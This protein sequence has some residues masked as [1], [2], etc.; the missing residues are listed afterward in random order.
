MSKVLHKRRRQT[1]SKDHQP[2]GLD[3]TK[4]APDTP[5]PKRAIE[6]DSLGRKQAKKPVSLFCDE[7]LAEKNVHQQNTAAVADVPESAPSR[8]ELDATSSGAAD[9]S[10]S[11]SFSS[12]TEDTE[13]VYDM[14]AFW[15]LQDIYGELLVLPLP[16]G[17]AIP[18]DFPPDYPQFM[19]GQEPETLDEVVSKAMAVNHYYQRQIEALPELSSDDL[20][21][22]TQ[23]TDSLSNNDDDHDDD[24]DEQASIP[25]RV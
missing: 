5:R 4:Q 22:Q 23:D 3:K 15:Y 7:V 12:S 6:S 8:T 25:F 1:A 20:S 18:R 17:V 24:A 21:V 16:S 11:T 10:A 13:F 19:D 14:Q 2:T 9:S